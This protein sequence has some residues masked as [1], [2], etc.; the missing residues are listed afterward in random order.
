[1]L[2]QPALYTVSYKK[3]VLSSFSGFHLILGPFY[4]TIRIGFY[5]YT[6]IRAD[7]S[8]ADYLGESSSLFSMSDMLRLKEG[9][10]PW[11]SRG[12]I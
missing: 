3:E 7:G 2:S 6:L 1:M 8:P 5:S 11:G 4:L 9:L 12:L 10:V